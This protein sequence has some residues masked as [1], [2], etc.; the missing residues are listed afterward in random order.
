MTSSSSSDE[1]SRHTM[2]GRTTSIS[3]V[4]AHIMIGPYTTRRAPWEVAAAE[5]GAP[6]A[7]AHAATIDSISTHGARR[8]AGQSSANASSTPCPVVLRRQVP[9]PGSMHD[10]PRFLPQAA[11]DRTTD[12]LAPTEY[13]D[14]RSCFITLQEED[15]GPV[16]SSSPPPPLRKTSPS[17]GLLHAAGR[18]AEPEKLHSARRRRE[19]GKRGARLRPPSDQ[20]TAIERPLLLRDSHTCPRLFR[21]ITQR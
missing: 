8:E 18:R 20:E 16:T 9:I 1:P 4:T 11:G 7:T 3:G 14:R 13:A 21:C 15:L 2:S 10:R 5:G 6:P 12:E 19:G 17:G